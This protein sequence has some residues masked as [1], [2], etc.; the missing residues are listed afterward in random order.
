[1]G[2]IF[3]RPR[4]APDIKYSTPLGLPGDVHFGRRDLQSRFS[5]LKS[6][7]L[8]LAIGVHLSSPRM[9]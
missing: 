8:S 2:K 3:Y 4:A 6:F 9:R 7:G 5:K 1:M